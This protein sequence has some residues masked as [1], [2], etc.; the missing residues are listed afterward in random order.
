[1]SDEK[2]RFGDTLKLV[3]RAKEDIYFAE[4]EREVLDKLR[5]QLRKVEK[6]TAELRCPKCQ[7]VWESFT[8]EGFALDRC[9]KCGGVWMDKGELEGVIGKITRGP[10]GAWIDTLTAKVD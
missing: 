5:S 4:R 7:G 2:D 9:S 3:E 10:L 8:Y 1:M 6:V